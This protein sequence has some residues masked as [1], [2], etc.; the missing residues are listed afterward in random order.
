MEQIESASRVVV[1]RRA[2]VSGLLQK[3]VSHSFVETGMFALDH[4]VPWG[5]S[6]DEYRRMFA[7]TEADLRL[8]IVGCGD[9]PASFNAEAT[10]RGGRVTSSDPIYRCETAQI[11]DRIEATYDE[12]LDE[13]RRNADEFV[14]DLIRSVEE[15]GHVR[16]AA[17]QEFLDDYGPGKVEGRYVAAELPT[18]RFHFPTRPS[19]WRCAPISC[20]CTPTN[21]ARH[22]IDRRFGRCAEWPPKYGS[23]RCLRWAA[24]DHRTSTTLKMT[25]ATWAT[26]CRLKT[27]HTSFSVAATR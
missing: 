5:R 3:Q 9:G 1:R 17:M 23:S 24:A 11:R 10:R 6:F 15:L 4:I 16:M 18:Q 13:T 8:R 25:F 26:T 20:F 12:I 22:F 2:R 7:L 21:W 14:W 19:I 27:S